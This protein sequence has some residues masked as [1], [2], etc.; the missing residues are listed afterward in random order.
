M[1]E[2]ELLEHE[3][4]TSFGLGVPREL[5]AEATK[6][7]DWR[8]RFKAEI[9]DRLFEMVLTPST[10]F[11]NEPDMHAPVLSMMGSGWVDTKMGKIF[12]AAYMSSQINGGFQIFRSEHGQPFAGFEAEPHSHMLVYT[13]GSNEK[14]YVPVLINFATE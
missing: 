8:G 5:Y 4:Q 11:L 3:K 13:N 10:L 12:Q 1:T 14:T 7:F 2:Q 9:N 6:F